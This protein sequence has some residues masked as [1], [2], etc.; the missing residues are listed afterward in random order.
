[1]VPRARECSGK[2]YYES[3]H[4]SENV[5]K[6]VVFMHSENSKKTQCPEALEDLLN[7]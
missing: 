6:Q 3:S 1:M 7:L 2:M 5:T 4:H